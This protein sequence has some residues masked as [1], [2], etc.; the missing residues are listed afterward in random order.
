MGKIW[1]S[2]ILEGSLYME[3]DGWKKNDLRV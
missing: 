2:E 3:H 1:E